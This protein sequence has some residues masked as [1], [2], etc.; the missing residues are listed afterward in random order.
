MYV[1][2]CLFSALSRRVGALRIIIIIIVDTIMK[3]SARLILYQCRKRV[4]GHAK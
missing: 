1:V 3:S 4:H 2:L